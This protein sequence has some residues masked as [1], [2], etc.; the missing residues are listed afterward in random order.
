MLFTHLV[1][2]FHSARKIL[3]DSTNHEAVFLEVLSHH[4]LYRKLHFFIVFENQGGVQL[5]MLK[6]SL[7]PIR[8]LLVFTECVYFSDICAIDQN[9]ITAQ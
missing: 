1:K 2:L 7:K 4:L 6:L 3:R 8:Y 5:L 9:G